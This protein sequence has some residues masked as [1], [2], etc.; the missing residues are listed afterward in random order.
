MHLPCLQALDF[1]AIGISEIACISERR[2]ERMCNPSLSGL[3]A[4]LVKDGGLNSGF[5]IA[6]CT[7]AALVAENRV[8]CHPASVDS[9]STSAAKED[10]V[11]MGGHAARKALSIV[12]HVETVIAI[13]LLA[14]C[15]ALDLHRPLTT[16]APLEAL[17]A[18]VRKH[19]DPWKCDRQMA[20]DIKAVQ[21]LVQS[22]ALL[23]A[24]ED[25]CAAAE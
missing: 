9:I 20:P 25:A 4:F 11:S 6:H 13:E 15:Q 7:A 22:G 1:L 8:L 3:P 16:T 2:L 10:H 12:E 18:L 14:A 24:V 17:Y 19:V 23:E 5:M 21:T